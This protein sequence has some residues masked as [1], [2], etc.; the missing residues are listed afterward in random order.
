MKIPK[1]IRI[2][3]CDYN[4]E[5]TENN[6]VA[7]GKECYATIDYNHHK[8]MINKNLGDTQQNELSF[9]YEV[10]HGIAR[11]RNLALEDEEFIVEEFARGL[12]Q[13]IKDNLEIFKNDSSELSINNSKDKTE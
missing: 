12:H 10:F 1:K 6:L 13:I 5:F 11:E 3:S 7:D 9:L 2:G 4:I 8:I